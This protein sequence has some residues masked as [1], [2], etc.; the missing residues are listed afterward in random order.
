MK[1]F[2]LLEV[3]VSVVCGMA[4]LDF[5]FHLSGQVPVKRVI[6]IYLSLNVPFSVNFRTFF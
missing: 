1:T 3:N 5:G 6:Y 2:F 4:I